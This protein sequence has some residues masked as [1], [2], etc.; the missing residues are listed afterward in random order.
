MDQAVRPS[1]HRV[2]SSSI[3]AITPATNARPAV[4]RPAAVAWSYGLH[5]V[6]L[7]IGVAGRREVDNPAVVQGA[8]D[9]EAF[10]G[11]PARISAES[12]SAFG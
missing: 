8:G 12:S 6:G 2:E 4:S 3:F 5:L 10:T 9:L 11:T 7:P 1:F